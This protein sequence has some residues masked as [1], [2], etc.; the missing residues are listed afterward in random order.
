MDQQSPPDFTVGQA[1]LSALK[2]SGIDVVFANAGTDFA[3]IIEGILRAGDAGHDIPRFVTVPHENVA[4]A[5]AQGYYKT[6]GNI[7]GVMVHVTVGTANALC[8]IM[9]AA[10]DRVPLLLAAGRTPLTE[11]GDMGSRNVPIHWGQE[12][13]DQGGIVREFVKWDYE[14][15]AGQPVE[16]VVSRAV[17]LAMTHPRGPVYLTLPRE[18]LGGADSMPSAPRASGE[19]GARPGAPSADTIDK[20]AELIRKAESPLI[21]AGSMGADAAS[22]E[23]LGALAAD[24]AIPVCQALD[25]NL[26]SNHPMLLGGASPKALGYADLVLVLDSIVPWMPRVAAPNPDATII[27]LGNDPLN[28]RIP[29]EGFR[30]DLSAV[31]DPKIAVALLRDALAGKAGSGPAGDKRRGWISD[32]R[33]EAA[34]RR[35][36]VIEEARTSAPIHPA[37]VAHC[38][39]DIKDENGIFVNELGL[40]LEHMTFTRPGNVLPGGGAGGLGTGLGEALGAKIA[41]PDRQVI[42]CVGDGSYMFNVPTAAHF[43]AQ[44]ENLPTLTMVSNNSEWYAVRRATL[45]VYPDGRASKSNT[46]PLVELNPSPNFEKTIEACGGRGEKLVDPEKVPAVLEKALRDV[47]D[48]QSV[49]LNII[50]RAGGRG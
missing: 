19:M 24:N 32:Y 20:I 25:L 11:T 22:F 15:R 30:S 45:A 36:A 2:Q 17:D 29:F 44:A 34:D 13:F 14:L 48:G 33:A 27:R 8:G 50:S 37:W 10:R 9:N 6:S 41:A 4:V 38:L 46:L 49:L 28:S 31:C 21:I 40:P 39:N 43:T 47:D 3:P 12:S 7:A 18:V 42:S 23:A 35:A 16:Q 26:P 5:M 1:Y